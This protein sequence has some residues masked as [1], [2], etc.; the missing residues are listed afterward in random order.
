MLGLLVLVAIVLAIALPLA[1]R[2][3]DDDG[4]REIVITPAPAPPL[5]VSK[6][7]INVHL[8]VVSFVFLM[9]LLAVTHF[10]IRCCSVK[11]QIPSPAPTSTIVSWTGVL[12]PV[13]G[14]SGSA[15]GSAVAMTGEVLIV[16][17]A[18]KHR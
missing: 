6:K 10:P 13:G 3:K 16:G 9:P 17:A 14:P 11:L 15:F 5:P 4:N 8:F 7:V 1:L 12:P 18:C 2:D